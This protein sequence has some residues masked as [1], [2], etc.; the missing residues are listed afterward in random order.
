MSKSLMQPVASI[1]LT[2]EQFAQK[3]TGKYGWRIDHAVKRS[4]LQ[5][6]ETS[7]NTN[8]LGFAQLPTIHITKVLRPLYIKLIYENHQL[9]QL[10]Q[11]KQAALSVS[12]SEMM[13][14]STGG[15]NTGRQPAA[16]SLLEKVKLLKQVRE[17]RQSLQRIQQQVA[18]RV[19]QSLSIREHDL[20]VQEHNKDEQVK[21]NARLVRRTSILREEQR[22]QEITQGL[23]TRQ[24]QLS[25]T[26]ERVLLHT[27]VNEQSAKKAKATMQL[28]QYVQRLMVQQLEQITTEK[29]V[30]RTRAIIQSEPNGTTEKAHKEKTVAV[31]TEQQRLHNRTKQQKSEQHSAIGQASTIRRLQPLQARDNQPSVSSPFT[32]KLAGQLKYFM[33]ISSAHI[34]SIRQIQQQS[35]QNE[36]KI[37]FVS[38]KQVNETAITEKARLIHRAIRLD[39]DQHLHNETASVQSE[40]GRALN[41][42]ASKSQQVQQATSEQRRAMEQEHQQ[43]NKKRAIGQEQQLVNNEQAEHLLEQPPAPIRQRAMV[44]QHSIVKEPQRYLLAAKVQTS[45][46]TVL[47]Q[48][49]LK[50][51]ERI[52]YKVEM[53]QKKKTP[54]SKKM[55]TVPEGKLIYRSNSGEFIEVTPKAGLT[56]L[57]VKNSAVAEGKL[58][59]QSKARLHIQQEQAMKTALRVE[60][61]QLRRQAQIVYNQQIQKQ[62]S[63]E[64][65]SPLQPT[66]DTAVIR[67]SHNTSTQQENSMLPQAANRQRKVNEQKMGQ[68]SQLQQQERPIAQ[69]TNNALTVESHTLAAK[70]GYKIVHNNA[71]ISTRMR[72][73]QLKELRLTELHTQHMQL[74]HKK[75]IE[76]HNLRVVRNIQKPQLQAIQ[77][78]HRRLQY[79]GAKAIV[80]PAQELLQNAHQSQQSKQQRN[81]KALQAVQSDNSKIGETELIREAKQA[82]A[83]VKNGQKILPIVQRDTKRVSI[84]QLVYRKENQLVELQLLIEQIQQQKVQHQSQHEGRTIR[85][86]QKQQTIQHDHSVRHLQTMQNEQVLSQLKVLSKKKLVVQQKEQL[87]HQ[88][89]TLLHEQAV[90]NTRTVLN[91]Q[92]T[93]LVQNKIQQQIIQQKGK[94]MAPQKLHLQSSKLSTIQTIVNRKRI[95]DELNSLGGSAALIV[96]GKAA[97]ERELSLIV[98]DSK[99]ASRTAV[100]P[101]SLPGGQAVVPLHVATAT[102]KSAN[103]HQE[104]QQ[105]AVKQLEVTVKRLEQELTDSKQASKLPPINMPQLTDQLYEQLAK[106]IRI[107]QHRNGR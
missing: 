79:I 69:L 96:N 89:Q 45:L 83:E 5:H 85:T 19:I 56:E 4:S 71:F 53:V 28:S 60:I 80:L 82:R 55:I 47:H 42:Q 95:T 106:K 16:E 48:Q 91:K 8:S 1:R 20:I 97:E 54:R 58:G 72:H 107:E 43:I 9:N 17:E 59:L 104:A 26:S 98:S 12:Q 30:Q 84:N 7:K 63:S 38:Q 15:S 31:D 77:L 39:S 22:Q 78:L 40:K 64:Q 2:D 100:T 73:I 67:Q 86:I 66:N 32:T 18:Q 36:Q 74:R 25:L 27:A 75:D 94:H 52:I 35:I 92:A 3:L 37:I 102:N 23:N 81:I 62:L 88:V 68:S 24:S 6:I 49:L 11:G 61:K 65:P 14:A 46:L 10:V 103:G 87:A 50:N 41:E 21:H 101:S 70:A 90:L 76:L 34:E 99:P 51:H 105:A 33:R 44:V 93:Q 29:Q 57:L 13:Q